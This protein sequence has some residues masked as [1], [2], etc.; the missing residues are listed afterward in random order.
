MGAGLPFTKGGDYKPTP[1]PPPLLK[2]LGALPLLMIGARFPLSP[3]EWKALGDRPPPFFQWQLG[4]DIIFG[5][6]PDRVMFW[7]RLPFILLAVSLGAA[8]GA[9]GP[10]PPSDSAP[11][12]RLP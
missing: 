3:Y 10:R 4:R 11:A 1:P 5:N 7:S 12:A 6:D 8:I 2:E 9:W